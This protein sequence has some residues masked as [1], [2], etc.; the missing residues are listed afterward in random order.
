MLQ[1]SICLI[2]FF[3]HPFW[4]GV[5]QRT[6]DAEISTSKVIFGSEPM[7]NEIYA[8]VLSKFNCLEFSP[9]IK[10][11]KEQLL[12]INPKRMHRQ[13]SKQMQQKG[14]S[15][16]SQLALSLQ[17]EQRKKIS[18]RLKKERKEQQEQYKFEL[19]MQNKKAK[20]RGK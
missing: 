3:E 14:N 10:D 5:F 20:H 19:R 7:D 17:M 2:D 1:T 15:T 12:K 18:S 8:Q 11:E 13:I 9:S 4:V 16:K 6:F